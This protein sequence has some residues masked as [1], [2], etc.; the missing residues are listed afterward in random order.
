MKNQSSIEYFLVSGFI[1]L[2]II[3]GF[4]FAYKETFSQIFQANIKQI[5]IN[6]EKILY[7]CEFVYSQGNPAKYTLNLNFP[8]KTK[9]Y[10]FSTYLIIEY[11]NNRIVY[12]IK[13]NILVNESFLGLEKIEIKAEE[14]YVKVKKI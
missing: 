6:I 9:I 2:I 14:N 7:Y 3:I 4:S 13:F 10:N 5:E 1:L 8:I 12:P 11:E